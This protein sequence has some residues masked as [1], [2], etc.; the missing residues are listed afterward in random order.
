MIAHSTCPQQS[1]YFGMISVAYCIVQHS[2][3]HS[4]QICP[5]HYCST[6]GRVHGWDFRNVLFSGYA[7]DGGMFMPEKVP[8]LSPDTLKCWRGLPYTKLVVE[9][10]SLFIPTELIPRQDL[11]GELNIYSLTIL[12]IT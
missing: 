3:L 4:I 2:R 8:V 6:R 1:A 12:Y 9:V 7:P 10:C 11:E 5:M